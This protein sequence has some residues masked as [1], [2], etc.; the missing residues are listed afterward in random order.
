MKSYNG[1]MKNELLKNKMLQAAGKEMLA[2][3]GVVELLE[4]IGAVTVRGSYTTGLMT[5]PDMDFTVQSPCPNPQDGQ[6]LILRLFKEFQAFD[7]RYTDFSHY[8]GE[9]AS[10]FV[11]F[12]FAYKGLDW[13]IAAT[14][15]GQGPIQSAPPYIDALL[16]DMSDGQR[17]VIMRLKN[18]IKAAGRYVGA[19]SAPPYTFRSVHLYEGVLKGGANSIQE[20]E[21]YFSSKVKYHEK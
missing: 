15:T 8:E 1:Y 6:K 18:E 3:S 11:G 14:V 10:Y 13:Q 16:K 12:K 9:S 5:Y 2:R 7:L 20:L 19:R 17:V 21:T 4:S